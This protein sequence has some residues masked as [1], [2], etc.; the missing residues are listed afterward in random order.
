MKDVLMRQVSAVYMYVSVS[1]ICVIILMS[2][3]GG[4]YNI[5]MTSSIIMTSSVTGVW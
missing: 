2:S 1:S 5:F 3:L 4:C